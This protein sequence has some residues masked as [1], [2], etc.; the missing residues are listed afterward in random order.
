MFDENSLIFASYTAEDEP[1]WQKANDCIWSTATG[2][3][4]KV[5]LATQYPALESFFVQKLG[6][7][8]LNLR[9]VYDEL[10][11]MEPQHTTTVAEI[12]AQLWSFNSLLRTETLGGSQTP[13]RLL[14]KSILPIRYPDGQ[15]S[16]RAADTE[17]AIRDHKSLGGRFCDKVKTLDFSD[18]EV[19]SLEPF[20][21]WA[22]LEDRY[23]SRL[24]KETTT[25]GSGDKFPISE[26]RYDIR[27]KAH[28]LL[29]CGPSLHSK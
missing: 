3:R 1:K 26:Q 2:L 25:L 19:R 9:M 10:L 21:K 23:I 16:L 11:G 18:R 17:F 12:K 8:K 27:K 6:I 20:L 22:G 29:R 13:P 4:G 28:G 5:N 15:V 14:K 24:V 7:Q